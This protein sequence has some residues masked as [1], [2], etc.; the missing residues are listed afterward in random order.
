MP[1]VACAEASA[2]ST[3]QSEPRRG[4]EGFGL[5][6]HRAVFRSIGR[7]PA[8]RRSRILGLTFD[9]L[10]LLVPDRWQYG[11]SPYEA[12]KRAVLMES[13]PGDAEVVL[14]LG[15]A[16]GHNLQ[17][18]AAA[19]PACRVIGVDVS[20]RAINL[21]RHST[22]HQSN[23][24]LACTTRG[25]SRVHELA[26][27]VDV[28]VLSEVLYYLGSWSLVREA[29][30][31]L[32]PLLHDGSSLVMVHGSPDASALHH[33]AA[34]A[35][36]MHVVEEAS[37]SSHGRAYSVATATPVTRQSEVSYVSR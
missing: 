37:R 24:H 21:A 33:V 14:E 7:L 30:S 26:V 8:S 35:L 27:R 22:Q 29:L 34:A 2:V 10:F 20:H 1:G 28:V 25:W 11:S 13:I 15:C 12:T 17:A 31:P 16:N 18:L 5:A 9:G 36:G 23:V 19:R 32:R 6:L 3:G 4:D